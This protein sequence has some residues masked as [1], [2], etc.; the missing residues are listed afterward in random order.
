MII[1]RYNLYR[2]GRI[3]TVFRVM[4]WYPSHLQRWAETERG[5]ITTFQA[6]ETLYRGQS[7]LWSSWS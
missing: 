4:N 7:R 1:L 5:K 2:E 6:L 3:S